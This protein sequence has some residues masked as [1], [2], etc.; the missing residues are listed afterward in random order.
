MARSIVHIMVGK[1]NARGVR[2]LLQLRI[3]LG[4]S[5]VIEKISKTRKF[6]QTLEVR[7]NG[8]QRFFLRRGGRRAGQ[9]GARDEK[10]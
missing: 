4:K 1:S 6:Y 3:E 10:I 7:V 8:V 2:I 9:I 5:D